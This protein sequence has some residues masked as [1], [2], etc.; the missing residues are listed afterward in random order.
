MAQFYCKY[1]HMQCAS[2]YEEDHAFLTFNDST[3][4]FLWSTTSGA[5]RGGLGGTFLGLAKFW[6]EINFFKQF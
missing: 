6:Y 1:M 4:H 3:M 2:V 5:A